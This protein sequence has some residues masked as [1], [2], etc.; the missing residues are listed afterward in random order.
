MWKPPTQ[1][2]L[3]SSEAGFLIGF[4]KKK[5]KQLSALRSKIGLNIL[6]KKISVGGFYV[7]FK[8][9]PFV[10]QIKIGGTEVLILVSKGSRLTYQ[11]LTMP[12]NKVKELNTASPD[13]TKAEDL[14]AD[15]SFWVG[16]ESEN[17]AKEY[18]P[19]ELYV[20]LVYEK[21]TPYLIYYR[22]QPN[23]SGYGGAELG[24]PIAYSKVFIT[25][26]GFSISISNPLPIDS[27]HVYTG[28]G[29]YPRLRSQTQGHENYFPMWN[30]P[31]SF[32]VSPENY[33][34]DNYPWPLGY[35]IPIYNGVLSI[36]SDE[37]RV[38]NGGE[39]FNTPSL[40]PETY[41]ANFSRLYRSNSVEGPF[42]LLAEFPA[43]MLNA[44][45]GGIPEPLYP[46][47]YSSD[48]LSSLS[49]GGWV[50]GKLKINGDML[51]AV[52]SG[53]WYTNAL[54]NETYLIEY[55]D[56]FLANQ[57]QPDIDIYK[58]NI[59]T[60]STD[61]YGSIDA[62]ALTSSYAPKCVVMDDL[63]FSSKNNHTFCVAML[64]Q[65]DKRYPNSGSTETLVLQYNMDGDFNNLKTYSTNISTLTGQERPVG[66][67]A[68]AEI[69]CYCFSNN[70]IYIFYNYL[71][72]CDI[73]SIII[74]FNL[75]LPEGLISKTD[76][77][78]VSEEIVA[79]LPSGFIFRRSPQITKKKKY[80]MFGV[81]ETFPNTYLD[82]DIEYWFFDGKNF[83]TQMTIEEHRQVNTVR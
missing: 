56:L 13:V 59:N 46:H 47:E 16:A 4:A 17:I 73:D 19:I 31:H 9:T 22:Y 40:P 57:I 41:W 69:G 54:K 77:T 45:G 68:T 42:T 1:V 25:S 48:Y 15:Y 44:H 8:S 32:D 66:E 60:G 79:T 58:I 6:E 37:E 64:G 67:I 51:Y 72:T 70:S 63:R 3:L 81:G 10:D 11:L 18:G 39:D 24:Y 21:I 28:P 82:N 55:G 38:R 78:I 36:W 49:H 74:K 61:I 5:V 75:E 26:S 27:A 76:L 20:S 14:F 80:L 12:Y 62:A 34:G 52:V 50:G 30:L 65:W 43:R 2:I 33:S 83:S 23:G 35:M 7:H 53:E 71:Y 29:M